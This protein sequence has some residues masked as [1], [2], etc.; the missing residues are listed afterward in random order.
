MY[1]LE[2]KGIYT[3]TTEENQKKAKLLKEIRN[4]N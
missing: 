4:K 3:Y 1:Y 2:I